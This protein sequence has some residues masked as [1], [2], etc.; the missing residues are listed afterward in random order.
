[1]YIYT[2]IHISVVGSLNE[3]P[4]PFQQDASGATASTLQLDDVNN[5]TAQ[6]RSHVPPAPPLL[7]TV[8]AI[9]PT[10]SLS[11]PSLPLCYFLLPL[12]HTCC[13]SI[14]SRSF[15]LARTLALAS[16]GQP[17]L[18]SLLSD[19]ADLHKVQHTMAGRRMQR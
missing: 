6:A 8:C 13:S 7:S 12:A 3:H 5:T 17:S 18:S 11:F 16:I 14:L 19:D 10:L 4:P 1:M 9:L 15:S 2:C